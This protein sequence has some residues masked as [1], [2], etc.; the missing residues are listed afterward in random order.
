M[1]K[2]SPMNL[3]PLRVALLGFGS[4]GSEVA[5]MLVSR[6]DELAA[7]IGAPVEIAGIAVRHRR[8]ATHGLD[9]ALFT[10]DP[11][12]LVTRGD[13]DVVIELIGGI[14][15]ARSL[16]LAAM[17]AGASVVTANKALIA[18]DGSELHQ[19]AHK[20]G[21]DLAYE[22]SVAGAVPLLRPLRESL[23]GDRVHRVAGIVNGTTNYILDRMTSSGGTFVTA[24]A[25]AQ[26][27]GYA[28][29]DPAADVKGTDAA[30]KVAI[31]ARLAFGT[32]VPPDE[33][34]CE[35]ITA[36]TPAD[37]AHAAAE[38][39]VIKLLGIC[40]RTEHGVSARVHPVLVPRDHPLAG[41]TGA[42]NGVF[43]EAEAAGE[44]MF[45]GQGAGGLPTASAVLGDLVGVSRNR[46]AGTAE[47]HLPPAQDL[48][49]IPMEQ[50]SSRHCL[51]M[52]VTDRPG[53]LSDV[54]SVFSRHGVS[55]VT[56][57]QEVLGA[58][59]VLSV[60]TDIA[61]DAAISAVI[62]D[63]R[64]LDTVRGINRSI[65]IFGKGHGR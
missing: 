49:L 65:R 12:G 2:N 8:A 38:N 40:D 3:K 26:R 42:Y 34:H 54:A 39:S 57:R 60:T 22:A 47:R 5:R 32:E 43:V 30:A 50:V 15:P 13:I 27:L 19:A 25:E 17:E 9:P 58:E 16:L 44:L 29:A 63:L 4:V 51:S 48:P 31:L 62:R 52:L 24:L 28:E 64:S 61:A 18:R 7:R 11:A 37:I 59:A 6:H 21:V 55:L 53:V 35:G 20:H 36:I 41:V 33:V 56:V 46:A 14:E 10:L 23:A 1:E 45:H